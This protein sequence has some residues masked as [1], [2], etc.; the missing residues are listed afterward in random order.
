M[1]DSVDR[2]AAVFI[3]NCNEHMQGM[4]SLQQYVVEA[5]H[6]I[7]TRKKINSVGRTYLDRCN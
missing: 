2:K 7:E 6:N 3:V 1:Q 4:K 5:R